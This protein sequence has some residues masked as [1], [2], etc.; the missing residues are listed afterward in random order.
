MKNIARGQRLGLNEISQNHQLNLIIRFQGKTVDVV[1]F[2]LDAQGTL[3]DERYMTFYNQKTT[4]CKGVTFS[5]TGGTE[6]QAMFELILD[7]LPTKIERLVLAASIDGAGTMRDIKQGS[8]QFIDGVITKATFEINPNELH[9]ERAVLLVEVYR[10][11]NGWRIAANG[12]GFNG[13]LD[14]LIEH[15]GG[16]VDRSEPKA[17]SHAP[18]SL[19]KK[20]ASA[21]P[22]LVDLAKKAAVSLKKTGLEQS[23]AR[24]ALVLDG[25]GSMMNQYRQGKVQELLN[26]IL[27]LAIHFDDDGQIDVWVFGQRDLPLPAITAENIQNYTDEQ[28]GGWRQWMKNTAPSINNEP[29]VME[30]VERFYCGPKAPKGDPVFLLFISDGG[31]NQNK[32]IEDIIR[33]TSGEPIF[34]QFVGIGGD[35]YGALERID[36][37]D[38]RVVD[39]AGFFALDDINDISEAELYD[40]LLGEFPL[41]L[42]A[43]K[44]KSII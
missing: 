17:K 34:W 33:R 24:V 44:Q 7:R 11:D 9:A 10:K 36:H 1:C 19:E 15:L 39:N 14:A 13:G 21:A 29:G 26:R 4:P 40:R 3:S 20:V 22:H 8:V 18:I 16:T 41:W 43:A 6:S 31:V 38:G 25:S 37:L 5:D 23:V 32:K 2:G 27:P 28:A 42:K 35:S 30:A 12:Q